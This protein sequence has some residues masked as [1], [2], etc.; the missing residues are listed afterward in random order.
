MQAKVSWFNAPRGFGFLE[1]RDGR[2]AFVHHTGV[3]E[4]AQRILRE[5][6]VVECE[7]EVTPKGLRAINVVVVEGA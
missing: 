3:V 7:V 6:D 1:L 2:A 5:A 4:G